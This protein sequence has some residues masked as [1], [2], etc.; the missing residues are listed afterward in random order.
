VNSVDQLLQRASDLVWTVR[1][2]T[3]RRALTRWRP[4]SLASFRLVSALRDNGLTPA[5]VIDVGANVGQFARASIEVFDQPEVHSFEPLPSAATQFRENLRDSAQVRLHP[6]ALGAVNGTATLHEHAY[7]LASS[8][9]PVRRDG[10]AP[11]W[12]S[13]APL[14]HEV[15]VRRLDDEL[16]LPLTRPCLLKIDVQGTELDVLAG[17]A[18]TL[19]SVDWI[20]LELT[21]EPV[22]QDEPLFA[23]VDAS[24][25]AMGWRMKWPIS[26]MRSGDGHLVAQIDALYERAEPGGRP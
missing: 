1:S 25:R 16:T 4:R 3:G 8:L 14:H 10:A 5:T 7:S 9:R 12:V 23:E 24:M 2:R 22:Y 18:E 21:F 6:V 19:R 15:P 20:L 13:T 11:S 26:A 17:A